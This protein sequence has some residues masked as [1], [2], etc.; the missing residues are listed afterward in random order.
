MK[1]LTALFVVLL[2]LALPAFHAA[3]QDGTIDISFGTNGVAK[4]QPGTTFESAAGVAVQT[5]GKIISVGNKQISVFDT[6]GIVC[7]QNSDGS[8][9]S[10]FG[11]NGYVFFDYN[12][13]GEF[14]NKPVILPDGKI[15]VAGSASSTYPDVDFIVLKLNP[16]GSFDTDFGDD[17]IKLIHL[18]DGEDEA[19]SILIQPDE[20][21]VLAGYSQ[22]SPLV[23]G[24]T[25]LVRLN[26]NGSLDTTF[27]V[28][29]KVIS[30]AGTA[31]ERSSA[32]L[33][34]EDGSIITAGRVE[35]ATLD[36]LVRKFT[37]AGAVDS[38]FGT[39][40]HMIL[41]FKNGSDWATGIQ[42][43]PVD[44]RILIS[45]EYGIPPTKSDALVMAITAN[46]KIDS[47]Y[48]TYGLSFIN[49]NASDVAN[50][51]TIQPDGKIVITGG[52]AP[53]GI[54]FYTCFIG[55]FNMNGTVDNT[56]GTNGY[57]IAQLGPTGSVGLDVTQQPMDGKL[58]ICG[59]G[60]VIDN[61]YAL[62]RFNNSCMQTTF[63][64]DADEDGFGSA[65]DAGTLFCIDPG[66]G[67]AINN[68]DCNDEEAAINPD[69]TE[70]LNG[71]DD[72]CNGQ[73]DEGLACTI[74]TGLYADAIAANHATIHW[75]IINGVVRYKARYKVAG[76][77][78]WI[79]I[80]RIN[81]N[82]KKLNG[83]MNNTSYIF[84]VK[85]ICSLDPKSVSDWSEKASFMTN[86]FKIIDVQAMELTVYPNP[87][88]TE[89]TVTYSV[90]S[91]A[92]VQID[93]LD[94]SGRLLQQV[95]KE[96]QTGGFH[97]IP[98]N[99]ANLVAGVYLLRLQIGNTLQLKKLVI[100]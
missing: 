39:S 59:L 75:D 100:E 60:V 94:V 33:L 47:T 23:T 67:Y 46:G 56:F 17:G 21:I 24:R 32:A 81:G 31:S 69:A 25:A 61:D 86:P 95:V 92:M 89:A 88:T 29:G 64:V 91:D 83:L 42:R 85:A 44:G 45:G 16:D 9:D 18:D 54:G 19:F 51:L 38:S 62:A 6:D 43:N 50:A 20:K 37:A 78:E 26:S 49:I 13:F 53:P 7:R 72:N 76:S 97:S 34:L 52:E 48:G 99:R 22:A 70:V 35:N 73:V 30:S 63:Y 68:N 71:V 5:D 36:L 90:A 57:T 11:T 1:K 28:D 55:R 4:L 2:S 58:V 82:S 12:M 87:F 15:L 41:N 65:A 10:T 79:T 84:Q 98:F 27:G 3:A 40:G 80:P 93:L 74:P 77:S 66:T 14:F 8:L 96:G